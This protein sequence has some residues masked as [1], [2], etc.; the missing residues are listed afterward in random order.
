M[1][2]PLIEMALLILFLVFG[3][4]NACSGQKEWTKLSGPYLGQKPPGMTPEVFAPD[5]ITVSTHSVILEESQTVTD[6]DGNVYRTV[7]IGRQTWMAENL[8]ATHYRDGTPIPNV[9]DDDVWPELRTGALCWLDDDPSS[10]KGVYGALYNYFAVADPRMLSPAGWH[11]PTI[12]EWRILENELG[13]RDVAGHTMRDIASNL[14]LV[15]HPGANNDSGFSARPAG[16]RGRFGSAGEEGRYATWWASTS[17]DVDFAWHWGLFPDRGTI[18]SNPGH[19][20]SGF[21]VR[22][23]KDP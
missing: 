5:N 1:R 22:C 19:K 21:S 14:W 7:Q 8:K 9:P 11:V 17:H 23:V 3:L 16:G 13:G 12:E 2:K 18:R 6:Y 15:I 4:A 20:A 10:F